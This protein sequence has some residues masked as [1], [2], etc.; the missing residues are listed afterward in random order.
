[1]RHLAKYYMAIQPEIS[2]EQVLGGHKIIKPGIR[3]TLALHFLA[4]SETVTS[5]H[6]QFRMVNATISYTIG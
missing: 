6:F 2:K 1:M 5:P 3:L 4:T